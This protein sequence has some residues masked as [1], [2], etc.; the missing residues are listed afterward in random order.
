[1]KKHEVREDEA[2]EIAARLARALGERGF[3]VAVAESLTG[4]KIANQLAAAP[5]SSE[6]FAGAVVCYGSQV[7]HRVLDVPEGPV[8]SERAVEVMARSV[9]ALLGADTSIAASGAGG[10][11]P[12]EGQEPGTTWLAVSIRGE[13]HTELHHFDGE[14]LDVLAQTERAALLLL[15]REAAKLLRDGPSERSGRREQP[16]G[17]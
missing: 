14:P 8:I 7:K 6:W 12:Q 1:M 13:V 17:Q 3:T 2:A 11:G 9:A 5:D 16:T 15:E 10:P 4:G